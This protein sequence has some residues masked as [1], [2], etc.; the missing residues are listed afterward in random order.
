[1]A[2]VEE[3]ISFRGFLGI[4]ISKD[5]FDACCIGIGGEKHFQISVF[6]RIIWLMAVKIIQFNNYFSFIT[7][8]G[9][10]KG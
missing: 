2:K 5:K 6:R 1:M 9:R 10:N 7:R 8:I 4:D 3:K